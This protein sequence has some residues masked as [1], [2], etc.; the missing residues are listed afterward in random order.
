MTKS[1]ENNPGREEVTTFKTADGREVTGYGP[2]RFA[3][4][5]KHELPNQEKDTGGEHFDRATERDIAAL[6]KGTRG[7]VRK[8]TPNRGVAVAV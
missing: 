3:I 4:R 7:R 5:Y 8:A 6:K 2:Y 1:L